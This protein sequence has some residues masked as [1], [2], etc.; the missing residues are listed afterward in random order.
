MKLTFCLLLTTF[1]QV[2]AE[3]RAQQITLNEQNVSLKKIF[4]QIEKQTG[5]FFV[6]RNEWMRQAKKVDINIKDANIQQV[7]NACLDGQPLTYT[8][9]NKNIV[10][11]LKPDN[12][13]SS[14]MERDKI[15]A[16]PIE[17]KVLDSLTGSPLQGVTVVVKGTTTGTTTDEKGHYQLNVEE[18]ATLIFSYLGYNKKEQ[19]VNGRKEINV[20]LSAATTGLS[21]LV[22]VGYGTQ[23]KSDL[24][25]AVSVISSDKL[26]DVTTDDIGSMLQGKVAG[27]Q[28]V[29]SSGAPG[30]AAEIRLRGISSV[31]TSQSPLVV[32][33][34]IIGGNYDPNDVE[35]VT[36]LKDAAGTAMY[37]SQANAGVLII[38]TKK[39]KD[40]KTHYTFKIT[41]GVRVPDFGS[42][43][44]M[45]SSQLYVYQ[46]EFYRDYI[47]GAA[48]NSYKIDIVKFH[49][50]RP[51]SLLDQ[52][53]N[54]LTTL[55]RPA[56][57]QNYHFSVM[58]KSKKSDYYLGLTYYNEDGTFINTD[59]KRVNLRANSTYHFTDKIDLTNNINVSG[60][61]GKNYDYNDIYYAYL[62]MPWDNPYDSLHHP[63]YVDGNSTFK[64][65]SRDK[66]NPL[67]TIE[68]SNHPWRNLNINYD[69]N[70]NLP[71][72]SWLTFNSTNRLSAQYSKTTTSY[73]PLVSG[74]YHGTGFLDEQSIL[75]YGA[76]SNQLLK[77]NFQVNDHGINGLL[78]VAFEGGKTEY[79]GASGKGLPEGLNVLNVVSSNQMVNGYNEKRAMQSI[80]S[81]INYNYKSKYF[82]TASYRIDGSSAFP[83]ENQYASFPAISG[84]WLI[85]H[86]DFMSDLKAINNLKLRLSYG[87]TGSQDIGASRYLGLYALTSQYNSQTAATP[88]QLPSP[89]LTWESK[90]QL[91]AGIDIGLFERISLSID[92]YRNKTKNLLLQVSQPTSVGFET[93]WQNLG[94]LTNKGV[95]FTLSTV[96]IDAKDFKW[97]MDFN[98]NFNNNIISGL[99]SQMIKTGSWGISQI[100]RNGGALYEFYLPKWVGVD[101]ETGAPLWENVTTDDAGKITRTPTSDFSQATPQ[102]LGSALPKVQGG[103]NNMFTYKNWALGINAYFIQGN[104]VYSNSLRFV[105][106]DGHE[107]YYN[108][109]VRPKGSVIW[110]KPGDVATEPSPQNAASSTETSSRFLKDGSYINIRNIFLTCRLPER[111]VSSLRVESISL[112]ASADNVITFTHFVGQDP[113]TTIT[114]GEFVTP[115]VSD[116]KYPNNHQYLFS[117][118][119]E[120]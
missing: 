91:N 27:L 87:V 5:Y 111:W 32:V 78:G 76:I 20:M 67:H 96:N 34:G 107:P 66:T 95:E 42:M 120:F 31:N 74:T 81:Q 52:N 116:F 119:V 12:K 108:Q 58:G 83:P 77:F 62:N 26:N 19:A 102:E 105:M 84:A 117:I 115:G 37:G 15:E 2:N 57:V 110:T 50:E 9:L 60:A 41:N 6:Y 89:D 38:T 61:V 70:L 59:Y 23:K 10:I 36:V 112:T 29:N 22:V 40:E 65:W 82:L 4:K 79:M 94:M 85:S 68:N 33:D 71:I 88:L 14:F 90:H 3:I 48:D 99:P 28:V 109:I 39:A 30:S 8:I 75:N 7:M 43:T 113:Q 56:P 73:S 80:I 54:W 97:N 53:T 17:G 114:P 98:I 47:P 51:L 45:N 63:I 101:K 118:N 86:E 1:L 55:F 24:T 69:I 72:T 93:R 25:S 64:W 16:V 104:K 21:Q 13:G 100:Y 49:N 106:N 35:S 11:G 46:K 92:A 18:N 103:L 44:M